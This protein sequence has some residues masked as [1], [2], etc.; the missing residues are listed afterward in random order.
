MKMVSAVIRTTSLQRVVGSLG[1]LG[2]AGITISEVKGVGDQVSVSGPYE[3]H[4]RVEV[5]VSDERA[6]TVA[7]LIAENAHSGIPGDGIVAVWPL[8][9][10]QEIRTGEKK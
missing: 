9:Y 7:K 6:D 10:M 8:D 2:V 4:N 1:K 5:I 3:V